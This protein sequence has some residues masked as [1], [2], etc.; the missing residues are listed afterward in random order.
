MIGWF[1]WDEA[2]QKLVVVIPPWDC[3]DAPEVD[4]Q[5]VRER[6]AA[7]KAKRADLKLSKDDW[8]LFETV[9]KQA[10]RWLPE[11]LLDHG[12]DV[13]LAMVSPAAMGEAVYKRIQIDTS[14]YFADL[15]AARIDTHAAEELLHS[16]GLLMPASTRRAYFTDLIARMR[17][18]F[19]DDQ[20]TVEPHQ[21][22]NHQIKR[23]QEI[24]IDEPAKLAL[25]PPA[26]DAIQSMMRRLLRRLVF[27]LNVS[28]RA[29]LMDCAEL[30]H[31]LGR[32]GF[33]RLVAAQ[34]VDKTPGSEDPL[35]P[36]CLA[37]SQVIKTVSVEKTKQDVTSKL[38]ER[39]LAD[40][41]LDTADSEILACAASTYR[42]TRTYLATPG[43]VPF[44]PQ[45]KASK[46]LLETHTKR[47]AGDRLAL[48]ARWLDASPNPTTPSL[49]LSADPATAGVDGPVHTWPVDRLVRW[50]NGPITDKKAAGPVMKDLGKAVTADNEL[51]A[52][53]RK[54]VGASAPEKNDPLKL[55]RAK[56]ELIVWSGLDQS[57][58]YLREDLGSLLKLA[59][60]LST[61]ANTPPAEFATLIKNAENAFALI[62]K[63][64]A[65]IR[66]PKRTMSLID[67][68]SCLSDVNSSLEKLRSG[69]KP[70]QAETDRLLRFERRLCERLLQEVL[71][72]GRKEGGVIDCPM[73]ITQW[74]SVRDRF[75][76]CYCSPVQAL[77]IN[78][79]RTLLRSD[80]ALALHV[81]ASSESG[82]A[83]DVSV[84]LWQRQDGS[85]ADPFAME[86]DVSFPAM[87]TPDW[88]DTFI[89]CAVLHVREKQ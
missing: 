34:L 56:A 80:Q 69:I 55:N 32:A 87:Q 26:D 54:R 74:A 58:D 64:L 2:S 13:L 10:A 76:R 28:N 65:A 86:C 37:I 21:T 68:Q 9:F 1:E 5:V 57:A 77:T 88:F 89:T 72:P 44:S 51:L 85:Q 4:A 41:I 79:Q 67:V 14:G 48:R 49:T 23:L 42:F 40:W 59:K 17:E 33:L 71:T 43:R 19:H 66:A 78:N 8:V 11:D 73:P 61:T 75:H 7:Q 24:F 25:A 30:V 16:T 60:S 6:W 47:G 84:H 15:K 31:T 50:I 63:I 52:T 83:F 27:A 39:D 35:Y 36:V 20:K 46:T 3:V 45:L 29:M 62:E 82:Y 18:K 38:D 12:T 22:I 81:T 70:V 53:D